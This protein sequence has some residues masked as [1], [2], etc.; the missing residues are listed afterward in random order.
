M[1]LPFC[2]QIQAICTN[3]YHRENNPDRKFALWKG[4]YRTLERSLKNSFT[5]PIKI[6]YLNFNE[7]IK[8]CPDIINVQYSNKPNEDL[9]LRGRII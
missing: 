2:D 3:D 5:C 9:K 7:V 6:T 1:K 8:L 4:G